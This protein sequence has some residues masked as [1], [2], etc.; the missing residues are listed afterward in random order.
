MPITISDL[1]DVA[2]KAAQLGPFLFAVLF[3]LVVLPLAYKF[4]NATSA[5][6]DSQDVAIL[7]KNFLWY[8]WLTVSVGIILVIVSVISWFKQQQQQAVYIYEGVIRNV[9]PHE[10]IVSSTLYFRP[11]HY[12][13]RGEGDNL[14]PRD[15]YF[16]LI[17]DKPFNEKDRFDVG[18]SKGN[19]A[20]DKK[21]LTLRHRPDSNPSFRIEW[22]PT[23]GAIKIIDDPDDREESSKEDT[24]AQGW[25]ILLSSAFAS[26]LGD[27]TPVKRN[28]ITAATRQN[29]QTIESVFEVLR[30]E[31][32]DVARK[33]DAIDQLGKDSLVKEFLDQS[34]NDILVLLD[35]TRHSDRELA[36]KAK[37]V[38]EQV[39][40]D[41]LLVTAL[42]SPDKQK[43]ETAE[44]ILFRIERARAERIL[45]EVLTHKG[46]DSTK[47]SRLLEEIKAGDKER[48]LIPTGSP[49]GDRYYVKA[50]WA[51]G[52]QQVS[53]CLA[54]LFKGNLRTNRT[55]DQEKQYMSGRSMRYVYWYSK[56]WALGMADNI[57]KCGGKATFVGL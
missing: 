32:K 45:E 31:V 5:G 29:D 23:D 7:R 3:L 46:G 21:D 55:L 6:G 43:K 42:S 28:G 16:L 57:Q 10:T 26:P 20:Q 30:Q 15:E 22:D 25:S 14:R 2:S 49:Q 19:D 54:E 38:A 41:A 51:S 13:P 11:K 8:F 53:D 35:L 50:E 4:V 56:A 24:H 39:W 44:T 18:F 36:Y 33:I 27:F 40:I 37:R 34:P 1:L 9:K 47:L 52:N 12:P 17:Q 48:L